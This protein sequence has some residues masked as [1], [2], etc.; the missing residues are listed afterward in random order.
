MIP[1]F[2]ARRRK[3]KTIK[4]LLYEARHAHNMRED[5]LREETL[6]E[7][8]DAQQDLARAWRERAG[9]RELEE[10][11]DRLHTVLE[12]VYPPH[13]R[14]RIR[15]FVEVIAVALVVAMALRAYFVQPFKIPTGSMQ[16]TL[17]GITFEPKAEPTWSD[18]IPF[19]YAKFLLLGRKYKEVNSPYTGT[20]REMVRTFDGKIHFD[21]DGR[22]V[23]IKPGMFL[24]VN[25]GDYVLAGDT[26]AGGIERAGDHIFVDKIRYNF[27]PPKRGD[28][29]VFNTEGIDHPQIQ[30]NSFYIKRLAGLPGESISIDPPYLVVDGDRCLEPPIFERV[31]EARD[32]GYGG[33]VL[34][35][36][37]EERPELL[38]R[39]RDQ[40]LLQDGQYLPLGD[41]SAHSLDGRYF[42]AV[43][44]DRIL[45]PAFLVYWPFTKRW[46]WV[47]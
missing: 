28:I 4:H 29:F 31:A 9:D 43:H 44:E 12:D 38:Y 46:G 11:M 32:D 33:Y 35:R 22:V 25:R 6:E 2:F 3:W 30:K 20:I 37:K 16:P 41:N 14:S 19:R 8:R 7:L 27:F 36:K 23:S 18:R 40:I 1:T 47:N 39:E 5:I 45:G 15:E 42:G 17:Y 13:T 10:A 24:H 26:L 21:I 34:A